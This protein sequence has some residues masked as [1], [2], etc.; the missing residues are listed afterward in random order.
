MKFMC[1]VYFE[2]GA[3]DGVSEAE[4][5][6]LTDDTIVEDIDMRRS[7]HLILGQPLQG[8]ET[9]VTIR[10]GRRGISRTDG[11]FLE[12]KEWLGGFTLI[13]ARDMDEAIA[14]T[15]DSALMKYASV[16]I[17]PTLEQTHSE[18]GEGRPQVKL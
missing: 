4:L 2:P 15:R 16:E 14:L 8:P 3:F 5:T 7:G 9:A 6:K 18:T 10:G 1:L 12:T 11:P 13:E 17:R